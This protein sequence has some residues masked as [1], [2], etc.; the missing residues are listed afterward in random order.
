MNTQ[1][2]HE[3]PGT[4]G[5]GRQDVGSS[6][7][8]GG[9]AGRG[10]RRASINDNEGNGTRCNQ[11]R[12]QGARGAHT[13]E[14]K[15]QFSFPQVGNP[16]ESALLPSTRHLARPDFPS[17]PALSMANKPKV[18]N[19]RRPH[20]EQRSHLRES[21]ALIA[22]SNGETLSETLEQRRA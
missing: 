10:S 7:A 1:T 20:N 15:I 21:R 16:L 12:I 3:P 18:P 8:P 17:V 22:C 19:T 14:T 5:C 2:V 9:D 13:H 6:E 4:D 11:G